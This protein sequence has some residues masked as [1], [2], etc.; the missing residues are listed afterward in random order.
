MITS[1]GLK[2]GCTYQ[3]KIRAFALMNGEKVYAP[4]VVTEV[5]T[6]E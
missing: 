1:S 3:Y 2:V 5:I 4:D 6:I